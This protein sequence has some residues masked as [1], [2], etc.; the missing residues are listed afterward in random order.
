MSDRFHPLP[1]DCLADW[2]FLEYEAERSIFDI[3]VGLFFHPEHMDGFRLKLG[4]DVLATPYGV[5]AGPHTQLASGILAS[6]LCGAR[7]LELKT[8]QERGVEVVRPCIRMRDEGLNVEWS[9]ELDP[10]QSYQQYL[11][12]WVLMYALQQTL[13]FPGADPETSCDISVGYDLKGLQSSEMRRYFARVRDAGELL[14]DR[15]GALSKLPSFP[16]NVDTMQ[17]SSRLAHRVTLS[18]LHGC[19]AGEI[20]AMLRYLALDQDFDIQV[21]LNPSLL[22]GDFVD[23][24]LHEQLG[25]V[26]LEPDRQAFA[27]DLKIDEAVDLISE[28][29]GLAKNAGKSFGIK[30]SNTL[31]LRHRGGIF[32]SSATTMYLSG[33]PLHPLT[34]HIALELRRRC[35]IDLEISFCGGADA[36]N[37]ADLLSCGFA[38]ITSCSDLL[39]PGGIPRLGQYIEET[40]SE[41]KGSPSVQDFILERARA[42]EWH[43]EDD[44]SAAFHNLKRYA[45]KTLKDPVWRHGHVYRPGIKARK[46]LELFDCIEAPCTS[47]CGITQKAPEYLRRIARGD[48]SGAAAVIREDNPLPVILGRTCHHPCETT[49]LRT[50][51]DEPLA[52]RDLKRFAMEYGKSDT[53]V[54]SASEP[55]QAIAVI[56]AGPC[57]LSVAWE[58]RKAGLPVTVFEAGETAGGM[59]H[60]TIPVY[61][62]SEEA[63]LRD[64]QDLEELGVIFRYKKRFGRDFSLEN[65]REAG[66]GPVVLAGGAPRGRPLGLDGDQSEGILDGLSFLRERRR[67]EGPNLHKMRVGVIGA[68]D[69]AMDCA[70]TARRLEADVQ[71]IYRRRKLDAPAHPEE[72]RALA[73]EGISF[74]EL[75]SPES[76]D[77]RDSR[78]KALICRPMEVGK[79][80][81]D[82]RPKP[83]PA[84]GDPRRIP[85]DLLIVAIGQDADSAVAG[86]KGLDIGSSGWITVDS[87]TGR[88]SLPNLWAGGDAVRGPSSIVDAAGDGRRIA[89]DI[90]KMLNAQKSAPPE[91][92]HLISVHDIIIRRSRRLRKIPAPELPPDQRRG[93]AEVLQTYGPEEARREA[94]RCLDCD[95]L[96]STCVTVCPNRAFMT[97]SLEPF[98]VE[99][100]LSENGETQVFQTQQAH[101]ILLFADWCNACGNCS[102]FCPTTGHPHLDKARLTLDETCFQEDEGPIFKARRDGSVF[103]L[104]LHSAGAFYAMRFDQSYE[105][106][107]PQFRAS[108]DPKSAELLRIDTTHDSSDPRNWGPCHALLTVGRA[109]KQSRP[110]LL[111]ALL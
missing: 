24:I 100:P 82:G 57:G 41:M 12:A 108:L 61:R 26:D 90:L 89:A 16:G 62:A 80:G 71:I 32:P 64:L 70:R 56:G 13:A 86:I 68:G 42:T 85:L 77:I 2:V 17:V 8:V 63:V 69:V 5:A 52:I 35:G 45:E 28:M 97:L 109:L 50:H 27:S 23:H 92:R 75:F 93:F 72:I 54:P 96:C 18:T 103:E 14:D 98:A 4:P 95:L 36:F 1:F 38:P 43:G 55:K 104:S 110:D 78:L 58:C 39:R 51:Y 66:F 20:S 73:E 7:T 94:S 22:G 84:D 10:D 15:L 33:R 101:Q 29:R 83:L 30:L 47:S 99:W 48:V 88:T 11:D 91:H 102:E 9:Q 37:A 44:F 74:V 60:A 79:P 19:P 81:P 25:F 53:P 49:C 40:R 105:F 67:G 111:Q 31:P 46:C 21:K 59:V 106:S 65:L 6:W 107:G 34:V 3:P 76:L 87:S